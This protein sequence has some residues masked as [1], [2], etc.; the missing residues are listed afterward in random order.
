VT[1]AL[2]LHH[3]VATATRADAAL[4][5]IRDGERFDVIVC[6]LMMPE[7]TGMELHAGIVAIAPDQADRMI[8]MTGGTFTEDAHEFLDRV[9]NLKLEKPF[10][11]DELVALAALRMAR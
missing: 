8:F 6:D 2:Q 9:D 3:E 11:L 1:L 10:R 7:M 4:A 5:R